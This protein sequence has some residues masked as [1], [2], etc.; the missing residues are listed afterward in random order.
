M[1]ESTV[2]E[3]EP[4]SDP[5]LGRGRSSVRAHLMY[6]GCAMPDV[7][8]DASELMTAHPCIIPVPT[9]GSQLA[10]TDSRRWLLNTE[11]VHE[12]EMCAPEPPQLP[13]PRNEAESGEAP[14]DSWVLTPQ[15]FAALSEQQKVAVLFFGGASLREAAGALNV[16]FSTVRNRWAKLETLH[17]PRYKPVN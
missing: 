5:T 12:P 6:D 9:A 15:R 10:G 11:F 13:G 3:Q 16:C 7:L 4:A 14:A 17:G 8:R 1:S 2:G